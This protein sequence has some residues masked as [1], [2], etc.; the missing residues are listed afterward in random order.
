MIKEMLNFKKV[1]AYIKPGFKNLHTAFKDLIGMLVYDYDWVWLDWLIDILCYIEVETKLAKDSVLRNLLIASAYNPDD[2]IPKNTD[3]CEDCPFLTYSKIAEFFYG[4]QLAG[5]CYFMKSG[6][7][8]FSKSTLN[9]WDG[10]KECCINDFEDDD[11]ED[12]GNIE[13]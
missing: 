3:Y 1:L 5:Y 9:L 7:F 6:D 2:Y 11:Y 10:C 12:E 8:S 13:L 4:G